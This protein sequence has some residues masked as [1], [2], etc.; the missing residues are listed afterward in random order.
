[1]RNQL[2]CLLAEVKLVPRDDYHHLTDMYTRNLELVKAVLCAGLYPNVIKVGLGLESKGR[3]GKKRLKTTMRTKYAWSFERTS[4]TLFISCFRISY[5]DHAIF[6]LAFVSSF[7][8]DR[9]FVSLFFCS[10]IL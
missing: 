6:M 1:M 5:R 3:C 7:F 4:Y 9:L 2:Y 8:Y 10:F